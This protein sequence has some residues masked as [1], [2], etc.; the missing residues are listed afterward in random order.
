MKPK[1]SVVVCTSGRPKSL[2]EC[3]ASLRGQSLK[4]I[5]VVVV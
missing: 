1:L 2:N 4:N 3:L 5:E